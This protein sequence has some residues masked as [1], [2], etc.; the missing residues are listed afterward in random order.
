MLLDKD[1]QEDGKMRID[2]TGRL[3][4]EKEIRAGFI[5]CGSHSFRNIYP[6]FQYAPVNLVAVCDL[7]IEKAQAY[8]AKFGAKSA[9]SDY[10]EMLKVENLDAVF[11]VTGYDDRGRPLYPQQAIDC[12][13]AGC[14]VWIEKPP[15]ATSA[16]IILMQ[17]A[18]EKAGRNVMVGMKKMFFPANEKAKELADS[19]DFGDVSLAVLQYPQS[20]PT[21]TEF[22]DYFAGKKN[23]VI[24]FLDHLCHPVSLMLYLFGMPQ[25]L[26]YQRSTHGAALATFTM[27]QGVVVSLVLHSGSSLANGME[28]TMI[29]SS[30]GRHI[31]VDNNV[32]VSYHQSPDHGYGNNPNYF[33]GSPAENTAVWEPEF[34][35]GQLYNK[36]IF[37]LGYYGE[38]NEFARSILEGRKPV[39]CTLD[40]ALQATRIFEAFAQGPGK[41]ISLD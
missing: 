21:G 18:A 28:R 32:R 37:L 1:K 27:K 7:S 12:L 36:G 8:A 15:A 4:D 3:V 9:Y 10:H 14:H 19:A 6:T 38:V 13:A 39:K 30:R 31:I 22:A 35:L 41:V 17:Q 2:F 40:Q 25:T 34:S 11:I 16:E 33:V 5:G 29:V 26:F 23:G 20:V 24:A